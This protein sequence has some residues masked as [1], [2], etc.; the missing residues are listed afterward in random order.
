MGQGQDLVGRSFVCRN[1]VTVFT[2]AKCEGDICTIVWEGDR[3]GIGYGV[4]QVL[5]YF[6]KGTWTEVY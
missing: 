5:T 6:N 2:I 4:G 3:E 1:D